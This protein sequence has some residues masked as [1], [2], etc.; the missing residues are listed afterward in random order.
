M[1]AKVPFDEVEL[2]YIAELDASADSL[3]LQQELPWIPEGSLHILQVSLLC[4]L[5]APYK[6]QELKQSLQLR[7]LQYTFQLFMSLH[8]CTYNPL[9]SC[10]PNLPL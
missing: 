4:H 7:G 2:Q 1:Q 6:P 5:A 9:S 8:L 10:L 3:F